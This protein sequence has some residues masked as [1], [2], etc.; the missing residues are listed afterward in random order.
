M[1]LFRRKSNADSEHV[2]DDTTTDDAPVTPPPSGEGAAS[3]LGPVDIDDWDGQTQV[4]DFGSLLIPAVEG[5]QVRVDVDNE[6]VVGVSVKLDDSTMQLQAFAA[7][8]TEG[9]WDDVRQEIAE[10]IRRNQGKARESDGPFG[11]EL[12]AEIPMKVNE[13]TSRQ[14]V[15]FIG[16]DGPRW[17]V[18]GLSSGA[19]GADPAQSKAVE[20]VFGRLVVRRGDHAAPPREPLPLVVPEDPGLVRNEAPPE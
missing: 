11:R 5:M 16:A 3:R 9:L 12:R 10:G 14:Q 13:S 2:V 15:R 4:V 19:G 6:T 1:S 17:F 7:P 20:A 8:R 18:R